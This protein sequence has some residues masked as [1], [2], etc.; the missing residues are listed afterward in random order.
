[1]RIQILSDEFKEYPV[2]GFP[3]ATVTARPINLDKVRDLAMLHAGNPAAFNKAA[4]DH[5][6]GGW[7]EHFVD[8]NGEPLPVTDANK[9]LIYNTAAV[10]PFLRRIADG[11]LTLREAEEKNSP[12][13]PAGATGARGGKGASTAA[14]A[15]RSRKG[16]KR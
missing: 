9:M 15:A 2:P 6:L 1:M 4:V 7:S 16:K 14:S 12:T 10:G 11:A 13:S 8:G 3:G 5:V